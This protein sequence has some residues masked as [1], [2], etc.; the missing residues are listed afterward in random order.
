MRHTRIAWIGLALVAGA[1]SRS[2]ADGASAETKPAVPAG[3]PTPVAST[4]A[5]TPPPSA[6]NWD[7]ETE[8]PAKWASLAPQFA[9]CAAGQHQ[10]PV[11]LR[12]ARE[13]SAEDLRTN[14]KPAQ[15]RVVHHAHMSDVVNTG[16]SVQVNGDGGDTITIGDE[17]Y[18]LLQYHFHSPGEHTVNGRTFPAELHL[19]HKAADGRL[20]VIGVLLEEGA[21]NRAFDTIFAHLPKTKGEEVHLASVTVDA[22]SLL[23]TARRSWRYDGSL[24]T[25]PCSEG[26]TWIVMQKPMP[27]SAAQLD[28]LRSVLKPNNRPVQALHDRRIVSEPVQEI[29]Q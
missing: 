4:R 15:L 23:P 25:P 7:Y 16:H 6:P 19:V 10:S 17:R 22:D 18:V 3:N 24:T 8:G 27:I 26:V 20:A 9:T 21:E 12:G 2:A 5:V 28:Q 1:C 11:D 29:G 13:A 14:Y